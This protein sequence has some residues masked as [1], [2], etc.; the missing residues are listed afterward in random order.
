[1]F[2]NLVLFKINAGWDITQQQAIEAVA[3]NRFTPTLPTQDKSYG[4][5]EPRG[6][7]HADLVESVN[8]QLILK[9]MVETRS[10]PGGAVRKKAQE[11]EDKIEAE[12]GRKPG[13]KETLALRE[14][15]LLS[16]LPNTYPAQTSFWVWV[17]RENR[18]VAIDASTQGKVDDVVTALVRAFGGMAMTQ[19]KTALSP[20]TAM[21]QWLLGLEKG[22]A[23]E[24][25]S[26]D[27]DC[28]L[29]STDEEKS[30]VKFNR[31]NLDCEE[32]RNHLVQ[33]MAPTKLALT[34][35]GRVSFQMT[36]T[37]ML[38]KLSFLEGVFEN[39]PQ[40]RESSFDGDVAL[41][42]GELQKLI[43]DLV[44]ALGGPLTDEGGQDAASGNAADEFS[45]QSAHEVDASE[46]AAA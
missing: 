12:T 37:M 30:S 32:V 14:D 39:L 9:L 16:L 2:K 23:P 3:S 5:V 25:F 15:A 21:T 8:G 19:I 35:A 18:C 27:R 45:N 26:V 28:E 17:D 31:H 24:N 43:P 44:D 7:D 29:K 36:E 10:V 1:M 33:G 34:W 22:E 20:A 13:K 6:E 40:D 42:T 46:E 41:F 4:W 11:A 38:K